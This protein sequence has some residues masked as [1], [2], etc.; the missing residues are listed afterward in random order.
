M[1]TTTMARRRRPAVPAVPAAMI[2][3][4]L[5][6]RLVESGGGVSR[7]R[8]CRCGFA[9]DDG[10]DSGNRRATKQGC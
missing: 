1:A 3:R 4:E 8:V 9:G 5:S 6:F 2:L 7:K 10:T